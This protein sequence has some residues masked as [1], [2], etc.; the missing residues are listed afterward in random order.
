MLA[1]M[2]LHLVKA[3]RPIDFTH[4][5][6]RQL[7]IDVM[8]DNVTLYRNVQN[9]CAAE[10]AA[11]CEKAERLERDVR[12]KLLSRD[13]RLFYNSIDR[14]VES[15]RECGFNVESSRETLDGGT[16]ISIY[17]KE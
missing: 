8:C 6:A 10:R 17:V 12:R 9:L 15:V 7:G 4:N 16:R 1:R 14:A 3:R 5:L 11:S 2:L 13:M